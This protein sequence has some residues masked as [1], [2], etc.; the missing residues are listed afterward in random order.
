MKNDRFKYLAQ[1]IAA[2]LVGSIALLWTWNTLA[3]LFNGSG[4]EYRHA[5]AA[6]IAAVM[7]RGLL[8][9]RQHRRVTQ[10]G[11]DTDRC[12]LHR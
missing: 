6:L 4:A 7:L 5:V 3:E 10:A 11:A 12:A 8:S 2:F 9:R 1:A